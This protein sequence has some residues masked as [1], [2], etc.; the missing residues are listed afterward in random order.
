MGTLTAISNS[1]VFQK[2]PEMADIIQKSI[3][4]SLTTLQV[5]SSK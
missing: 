2:V 4:F 5:R 3:Y 1:T